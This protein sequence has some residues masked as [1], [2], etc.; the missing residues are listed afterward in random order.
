MNK[1][2]NKSLNY[3]KNRLSEHFDNYAVIA[4]DREGNLI[5]DYNNWMVAIMLIDRAKDLIEDSADDMDIIWDDEDDD[6]DG[7]SAIKL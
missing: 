6:D 7:G 2:G 4:I 1:M 3:I 5:W